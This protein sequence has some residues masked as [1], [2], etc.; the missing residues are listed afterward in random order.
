MSNAGRPEEI[1]EEQKTELIS[2]Y[3]SGKYTQYELADMYGM[4]QANVSGILNKYA[5]D[6]HGELLEFIDESDV[7]E[8]LIF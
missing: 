6:H 4:T 2:A 8:E 1:S 3:T 7:R 5:L